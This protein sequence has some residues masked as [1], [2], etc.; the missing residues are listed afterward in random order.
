MHAGLARRSPGWR[1]WIVILAV[2]LVGAAS[3]ATVWHGDHARDQ[4]CAVCQLRQQ[5]V[6]EVVGHLE[7]D[8]RMSP[9]GWSRSPAADGLHPIASPASPPAL[10]PSDGPGRS[11]SRC[12]R[13]KQHPA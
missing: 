10:R 1:A 8:P 5:P 7:S 2:A 3:V 11:S 9:S 13:A 6:A 12:N 4:D